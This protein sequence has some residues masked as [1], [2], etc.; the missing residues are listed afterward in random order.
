MATIS[1]VDEIKIENFLTPPATDK[2]YV[3]DFSND[4]LQ[5]FVGSVTGIDI[6]GEGKYDH[7]GTSKAKR[8][9]C[10]FDKEPG[11]IVGKVLLELTEYQKTLS[12]KYHSLETQPHEIVEIANKLLQGS[13]DEDDNAAGKAYFEKIREQILSEL[14]KAEFTIWIAMAWFTDPILFNCLLTKRTQGLN[15]QIIV[16]DDKTNNSS[17][18]DYSQFETY[19]LPPSGLRSINK[20]HHKFCIIDFKTVIHGS[21]NWTKSARYND[22]T[23]EI[24]LGHIKARKFSKEFMKLK[25]EGLK[26]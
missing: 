3:L 13:I 9:K 14:E 16:N 5:K 24:S 4:K 7:Y 20:M 26:Q 8:L 25:L 11:H 18:L 17:D 12:P 22:E 23:I 6:Y 10:F 15:I 2:G 19:K 1:F 21:Y